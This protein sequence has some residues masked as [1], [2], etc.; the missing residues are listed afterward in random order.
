MARADLMPIVTNLTARVPKV[1]IAIGGKNDPRLK[2]STKQLVGILLNDD[3]VVDEK[4]TLV[5]QE[6]RELG[7]IKPQMVGTGGML[8]IF[9][10]VR[11]T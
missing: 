4:D 10:P 9:V 8:R 5:L 11:S 1:D 3:V 7:E 6:D 2:L